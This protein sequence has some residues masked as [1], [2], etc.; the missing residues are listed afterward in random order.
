MNFELDKIIQVLDTCI[1]ENGSKSILA[2]ANLRKYNKVLQNWETIKNTEA[3][4]WWKVNEYGGQFEVWHDGEF[5]FE[6]RRDW[7]ISFAD[8]EK[9]EVSNFIRWHPQDVADLNR[10]VW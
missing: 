2:I 4:L 7:E 10:I 3:I 1:Q 9:F 8:G 6:P 5:P